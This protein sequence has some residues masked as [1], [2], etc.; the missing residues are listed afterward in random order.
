[1]RRFALCCCVAVL[2]G[3]TKAEPRSTRDTTAAAPA[4][5]A[6]AAISL[7]DV[8]GKWSMRTMTESGESTL[9][10]YAMVAST[11][12]SG[13]TINFSNRKP[14]PIRVIAVDGDSIVTEAGPYESV[15]RKGVQVTTHSVN[16]LQ[17]GKLVG[18]IM[19]RYATS[20]PDSVLHLRSEGTRAP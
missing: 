17:Y 16:R 10:N 8:A 15:L 5:P 6:P 12:P 4:T 20:R 3:C 14:I 18:T 11:D 2:V 9:V 13:W 19:A 1:M 7:A